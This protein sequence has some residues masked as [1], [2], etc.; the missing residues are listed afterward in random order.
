LSLNGY[1][2]IVP[3]NCGAARCPLVPLGL[4]V[5]ARLIMYSVPP[6]KDILH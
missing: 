3:P 2:E 1:F 6:P 5:S 4:Q